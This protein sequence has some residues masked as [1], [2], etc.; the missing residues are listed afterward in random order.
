VQGD[1][2]QHRNL[3]GEAMRSSE[4][5][6]SATRTRAWLKARAVAVACCVV[7]VAAAVGGCGGGGRAASTSTST[8]AG[9]A[10]EPAVRILAAA[11]AAID[12]VHSF[13]LQATAVIPGTTVSESTYLQLPGVATLAEQNGS[14]TLD[15]RAI[16]GRIYFRGNRAY[17]AST[18]VTGAELAT[19]PGRWVSATPAQ[20][21][22]ADGL[23]A[24]THPATLGLC[25][26]GQHLGTLSVGGTASVDGRRAVVLLDAGNLPGSAPGRIYIAAT[27]P[28]LPLR[29]T[30]TGPARPGGTSD[31]VCDEPASQLV[32]SSDEFI[33]DVN[34]PLTITAPTGAVSLSSATQT[35]H[36]GTGIVAVAVQTAHTKLGTIG[37]RSYGSGPPLVLIMGYGGTMETWDPR[38]VDTLAKHYRVVI[39]DNAGVGDTQALASPLTIDAMADQTSALIDSLGLGKP[40]VLGWSMGG[41]IAQALADKT[42]DPG[43]TAG[44]LR[45]VPRNRQGSA[46]VA[47]RDKRALEHQP[48]NGGSRPVPC[49]PGRGGRGVRGGDRWISKRGRAIGRRHLGAGERDKAMVGRRRPGSRGNRRDHRADARRGRH[50]RPARP[51]RQQPRASEADP[52]SKARALPRRRTRV[53]VP[54]PNGLHT[55]NRIVPGLSQLA[56]QQPR[57]TKTTERRS[58]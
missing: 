3:E 51:S 10:A 40:D 52:G 16:A 9:L 11:E 44:A 19:L 22:T 42:P 56:D 55:G 57:Q 28:P 21:P 38:F 5:Q 31:A 34:A 58:P 30:R 37:Y 12:Q 41:M 39:F 32:S 33:T 47:G 18:G 27:G 54:G 50:P 26:L 6:P 8:G 1:A 29:L 43:S 45:D 4:H 49:Q 15:L 17:Y 7:A 53:P 48:K 20:L 25:L 24:L 13:H 2:D 23:L 36:K 35:A 46:A 14:D